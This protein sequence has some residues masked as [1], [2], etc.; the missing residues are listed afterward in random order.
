MI[1]FLILFC[2]NRYQHTFS[3]GRWIEHPGERV[4][5]VDDFLS[6]FNLVGLTES[7]VIALLGEQTQ[8]EYF[9]KKNR[10]VYYLGNE[11]G[12]ISIDSE[13]LILD[14]EEGVVSHIDIAT[15]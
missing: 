3:T 9:N 13:W 1:V 10:W 5:M 8:T 12:W 11:R 7:E 4:K 6:K 2:R 14:F 15:D